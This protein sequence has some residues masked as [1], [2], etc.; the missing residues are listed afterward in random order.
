MGFDEKTMMSREKFNEMILQPCAYCGFQPDGK[1][2]W[3]SVDRID[4]W[5]G[6]EDDNVVPACKHCNYTKG[7]LSVKQLR[8][9]FKRVCEHINKIGLENWPLCE[10]KK[11]K[12]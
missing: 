4:S 5:K 8:E 11:S 3:N 9:Y 6:Y 1:T 10:N 7:S 12:N 2:S